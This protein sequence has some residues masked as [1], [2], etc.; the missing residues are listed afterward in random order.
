MPAGERDYDGVLYADMLF[1]EV[2]WSEVAEHDPA[3]RAQRKGTDE[4]NVAT[5]WATEACQ[6][7]RR[8]VRTAGSRSG[9]TIKVTGYSPS[10]DFLV[11]AVVAPKDGPAGERWWG[12]SA[13]KANPRDTR[14]YEQ[15]DQER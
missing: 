1:G 14:E 3:K 12:A 15:Q 5:E 11:T 10:A 2:D 7:P 4:Q 6:D 13:W 8:W 9:M